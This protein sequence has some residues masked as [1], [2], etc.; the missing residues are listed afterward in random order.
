M[1]FSLEL[2]GLLIAIHLLALVGLYFYPECKH[3]GHLCTR[4]LNA[5][6]KGENLLREISLNFPGVGQ[7]R[8]PDWN[9]RHLQYKFYPSMVKE[10]ISLNQKWGTPLKI[11]WRQLKSGLYL[12]LQWHKRARAIVHEALMQQGLMSGFVLLFAHSLENLNPESPS[13]IPGLAAFYL[14]GMGLLLVVAQ[15]L[16][17]KSLAEGHLFWRGLIRLE[18]F[19]QARL[20]VRETLAKSGL[21]KALQ[22]SDKAFDF[23]RSV[24]HQA[25]ESWQKRGHPLGETI[26]DLR[27]E[28]AFVAE[29]KMQRLLKQLKG[30]QMACAF[31]FILPSFFY[32]ISA[33]MGGLFGE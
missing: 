15:I 22:G 5:G 6:K 7:F 11:P 24:L 20:S 14:A 17:H 9:A 31:V 4:G 27:Q 2:I 12:D 30:L 1:S 18:V 8:A 32:L 13:S 26:A 25:L 29:Q 21:A 33:Q 19:V 3:L 16:E 23:M 28:Y 10:L